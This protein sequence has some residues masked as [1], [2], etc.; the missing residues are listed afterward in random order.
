[1]SH[2]SFTWGAILA[3]VAAV[4]ALGLLPLTPSQA[5]PPLALT[6]SAEPPTRT[7]TAAT[8]V[9]APEVTDVPEESGGS[10]IDLSISKDVSPGSAIPGERVSFVLTVVCAGRGRA[11]NVVISDTLPE[12]LALVEATTSWGQL[13]TSGRTVRVTIPVL[14]AGD[15][16]TVR[17]VAQVEPGAQGFLANQATVTT[18]SDD[19]DQANNTA[20]AT[21]SVSQPAVTPTPAPTDTPT[22][23]PVATTVPAALPPTGG[24]RGEPLAWMPLALLGAALAAAG[25]AARARA[26]S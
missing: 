12:G 25:L 3:A 13:T 8:P 16:V 11:S 6:A 14:Y 15:Q 19:R 7:P 4:L 17:V 9:P 2:R 22:P 20:S 5:A 10:S 21:L 1:M 23:G 26:R 24:P 18:D